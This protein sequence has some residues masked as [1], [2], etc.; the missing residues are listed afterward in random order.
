MRSFDFGPTS[1]I[2]LTTS[3]VIVGSISLSA[4][5]IEWNQ[6]LLNLYE[7][8]SSKTLLSHRATSTRYPSRT[9]R[10]IR[11]LVDRSGRGVTLAWTVCCRPRIST[12]NSTNRRVSVSLVLDRNSFS[13]TGVSAPIADG[14]DG[15]TQVRPAP[16]SIRAVR[17]RS[18]SS[19]TTRT[20]STAPRSASLATGPHS[21][22]A[23]QVFDH[24]ASDLS[25]NGLPSDL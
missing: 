14:T 11:M 18:P 5:D 7:T 22:F 24:R 25:P 23:L 9:S 12:T 21:S 17:I 16:V 2:F 8:I 13:P 15:S 19:P 6:N 20:S 4:T 10:P 3:P 1:Y